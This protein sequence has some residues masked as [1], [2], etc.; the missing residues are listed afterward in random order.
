MDKAS[1]AEM[2]KKF[3]EAMKQNQSQ[4]TVAVK[5]GDKEALKRFSKAELVDKIL[6]M[7]KQISQYRSRDYNL[8]SAA[9]VKHYEL[10]KL[11]EDYEQLQDEAERLTLRNRELERQLHMRYPGGRAPRYSEELKEE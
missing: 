5:K 9:I 6:E 8:S 10:N 7:E 2:A 1:M 4:L 3:G 11:Q